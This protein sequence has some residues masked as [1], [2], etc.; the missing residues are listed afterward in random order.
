M[1]VYFKTDSRVTADKKQALYLYGS[2]NGVKYR[3]TLFQ[4]DANTFDQK[5]Q[6]IKSTNIRHVTLNSRILEIK[7]NV[8]KFIT[9]CY[10]SGETLEWDKIINHVFENSDMKTLES[11]VYDEIKTNGHLY[12]DGTK[13]R[14]SS[15]LRAIQNF[16][17]PIYLHDITPE[18]ISGVYQFLEKRG[19]QITS[20]N[21]KLKF[22]R[23]FVRLAKQKKLIKDNPFD[24]YTIREKETTPVYLTPDEL[25]QLEEFH[26]TMPVNYQKQLLQKFLFFCFTGLRISD[27][28]K[29][30]EKH[31]REKRIEIRMQKTQNKLIIPIG[32]RALKYAPLTQFED[33]TGQYMNRELKKIMQAAGIDKNVTTKT[34]RHS[35]AVIFLSK[36]G[37]LFTLKTLLGH[38]KVESTLVYSRLVDTA[39][40]D[41]I[42][43]IDE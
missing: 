36:G 27:W 30:T 2:H 8:E 31:I 21:T 26:D 4:I 43:L 41:Q 38:K 35:F 25:T 28:H 5:R 18:Y 32:K 34:A 29:V 7:Y 24:Y 13:L 15:N 33:H 37:N 22:L 23:K 1:K 19:N 20:I 6:Q 39:L 40:V 17:K 11:L 9:E 42:K 3:K 12:S 14:Y 16:K 10:L